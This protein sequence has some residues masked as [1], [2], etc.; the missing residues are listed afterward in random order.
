MA[1]VTTNTQSVR[2][3]DR[4]AVALATLV[5]LIPVTASPANAHVTVTSTWNIDGCA[6]SPDDLNGWVSVNSPSQTQ[7]Q[8]I[9]QGNCTGTKAR[10]KYKFWGTWYTT[11][12]AT[13]YYANTPAYLFL[14]TD[15]HN[16]EALNG[17]F[18]ARNRAPIYKWKQWKTLYYWSGSH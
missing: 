17:E 1:E 18:K 15:A 10:M 6:G 5:L 2:L 8:G 9:V 7:A 4:V 13:V 12:T 3:K 16:Y 11:G 14:A